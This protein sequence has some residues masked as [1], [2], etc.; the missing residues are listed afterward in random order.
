MVCELNCPVYCNLCFYSGWMS[1]LAETLYSYSCS[2]LSRV[3]FIQGIDLTFFHLSDLFGSIDVFW[4]FNCI[5]S[6]ITPKVGSQ[7]SP[8]K[9]LSSP[10]L[11]AWCANLVDA[12]SIMYTLAEVI[13]CQD[14]WCWEWWNGIWKLNLGCKAGSSNRAGGW[15]SSWPSDLWPYWQC[16]TWRIVYDRRK[17]HSPKFFAA[18]FC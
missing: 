4:F 16:W 13:W 17:Y 15:S 11:K 2:W 8:V 3:M 1:C 9:S 18:C 7:E 14:L 12:D 6:F 5:Y 10:N